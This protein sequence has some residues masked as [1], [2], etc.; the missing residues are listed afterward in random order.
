M[1]KVKDAEKELSEKT[2]KDIQTE[3]A[4]KWASRAAASYDLQLA[5][6][7][8]RE[9]LFLWTLGEEYYHEAIEHAALVDDKAKLLKKLDEELA[10]YKKKA[11]KDIEQSLL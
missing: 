9:K 5:S 6:K 3:T 2:Y 11:T 7:S 8:K 4:W 10:P 1:L